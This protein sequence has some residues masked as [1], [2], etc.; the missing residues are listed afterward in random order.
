VGKYTHQ[1]KIAYNLV[2][3]AP[4]MTKLK[5]KPTYTGWLGESK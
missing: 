4:K 3:C 2:V 1:V 5:T